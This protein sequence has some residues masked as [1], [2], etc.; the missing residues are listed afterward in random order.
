KREPHTE[1]KETTPFLEYREAPSD[2]ASS[3]LLVYSES[4][5]YSPRNRV[6]AIPR[7]TRSSCGRRRSEAFIGG[8]FDRINS[9]SSIKKST[10]HLCGHIAL[11]SGLRNRLCLT[12][13]VSPC[14][15][16][17]QSRLTTPTS[18]RRSASAVEQSTGHRSVDSSVEHIENS[19]ESPGS[20]NVCNLSSND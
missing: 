15:E 14:F 10:N 1:L 18:R 5:R 12:C 6:P 19:D 4:T 20:G 9:L 17:A 2:F 11:L 8:E 16:R 3:E 13:R 7:L